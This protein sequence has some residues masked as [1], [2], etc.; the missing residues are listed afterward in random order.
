MGFAITWFAVPEE[1]HAAFC[2]RFGLAPTGETLEVPDCLIATAK[3]D[4]GWRLIWYGKYDCPFIGDREMADISRS[5]DIVRCQVEEHVMASRSELWSAG[6]RKWFVSHE[7]EDGPK[8]LDVDGVLPDTFIAMKREMEAIQ[9]AEGGESADVDYIFEIPLRV[10]ESIVGFKHDQSCGHM[11]DG[12]FHVM[13]RTE[14]KHGLLA[15]L[16]GPK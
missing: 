15:R 2:S 4:T 14:A 16:F 9:L 13:T 3:L 12:A 6:R 8:G 10:A 1:S 7:G 5:Y 11:P